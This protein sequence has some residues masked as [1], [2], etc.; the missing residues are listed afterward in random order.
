MFKRLEFANFFSQL[1][2]HEIYYLLWQK[3]NS[4]AK[5]DRELWNPSTKF[6][7]YTT[8][9]L[10][11]HFYSILLTKFAFSPP[12]DLLIKFMFF[13]PILWQK[14]AFFLWIWDENHVLPWSFNESRVFMTVTNLLFPRNLERNLLFSRIF[15]QKK[16][17][18]L[19][20]SSGRNLH[21]FAIFLRNFHFFSLAILVRT[22]LLCF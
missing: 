20:R 16:L 6:I 9:W 21:F 22:S 11:S 13:P 7:F 3:E 15:S 10:N 17:A 19:P 1:E 14:F 5:N 8:V 12:H 2:I 4:V 18:F